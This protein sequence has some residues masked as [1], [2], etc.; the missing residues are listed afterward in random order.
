ME[1]VVS[2]VLFLVFFIV[3]AKTSQRYTVQGRIRFID[4]YFFPSSLA[5][6]VAK[7]YP[8]LS[9]ADVDRVIDGLRE[10][11]HICH[12]AGD[13]AVAMPSQ[14]V[15]V[16]WHEFILSTRRYE[17]FCE[18]AFGRFL[19]HTPAET[20]ESATVAQEGI[21]HAWRLCCDRE[22]LNPKA[23][24][25]LPM[26]FAMD[27]VLNISDGF[28]YT[29]NCDQKDDGVYCATHIGCS[30]TDLDTSGVESGEGLGR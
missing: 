11:F 6:K 20:M 22:K 3:V 12:I 1:I 25:K 4:S 16:A 27:S 17:V 21:K 18:R 30:A 5:E 29:L 7:T 23:A 13:K 19:H 8:H 10:Y 2:A 14:V 24:T 15:D 28:I 26:L 9:K